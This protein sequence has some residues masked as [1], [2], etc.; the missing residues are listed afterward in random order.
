MDSPPAQLPF[1]VDHYKDTCTSL[2][3][4]RGQRD[5]LFVYILVLL[6]GVLLDTF[7]PGSFRSQL[8]QAVSRKLDVS[9]LLDLRAISIL[10]WFALLAVVVRYCQATVHI[11][12]L[13][14]YIHLLEEE[15][16]KHF[17]GSAYTREGKSYYA[18][19]PLFTT[20]AHAMY[21]WAF[22]VLLILLALIRIGLA[23]S[24]AASLSPGLALDILI[25][26]ALII[27]LTL[28]LIAIHRPPSHSRVSLT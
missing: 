22:P 9:P 17:S 12:R 10:L 24:Q 14:S 28:Y 2:Q 3:L 26:S 7:S 11:E 25:G 27:T 13:Y 5:S 15:L 4:H 1:L 20:W 21:S 19:Y 23:M 18:H 16:R 8:A 6:V